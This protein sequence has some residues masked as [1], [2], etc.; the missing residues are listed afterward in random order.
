MHYEEF[1]ENLANDVKEQMESRSG[2]GVA[3]ETK[4]VEKIDDDCKN[5]VKSVLKGYIFAKCNITPL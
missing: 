3:V 4:T 5:E 2:S 1:K